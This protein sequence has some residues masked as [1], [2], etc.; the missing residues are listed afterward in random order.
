[1][2]IVF[3]II[4]LLLFILFVCKFVP[5]VFVIVK[6]KIRPN[7]FKEK[8]DIADFVRFG[9]T[10]LSWFKTA[11]KKLMSSKKGKRPVIEYFV[12]K[13]GFFI[14]APVVLIRWVLAYI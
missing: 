11:H 2:A 7:D 14:L 6:F 1:M 12:Y 10:Y 5:L 8:G 4:F 9:K 3:N 13:Y